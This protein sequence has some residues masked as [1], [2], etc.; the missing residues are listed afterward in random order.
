MAQRG[1]LLFG[2]V[3]IVVA[4]LGFMTEGGT[5]MESG[6]GHGLLL[7]M[8][9]VNLVHNVVHLLFGILGVAASRSL[10]ATRTYGRI[11]AVIYVVLAVLAFV[12]PTG[13]GIVPIGGHDVWLHTI[14]AAGLAFIGFAGAPS[15]DS[16][17]V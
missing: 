1:A 8:F 6:E 10:R 14:L 7:G 11:G 13:F 2:I 9:P 17:V 3:F 15:G 16:A 12:D 4:I 5:S